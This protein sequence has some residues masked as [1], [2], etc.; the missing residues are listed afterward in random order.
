MPSELLSLPG[1]GLM[2]SC[3][4]GLGSPILPVHRDLKLL[5]LFKVSL[6]LPLPVPS[7]D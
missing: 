3:P 1:S 2:P 7:R 4:R 5:P 6:E